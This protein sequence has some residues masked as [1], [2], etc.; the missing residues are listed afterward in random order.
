MV[1]SC[2]KING[3]FLSNQN[4]SF[5]SPTKEWVWF[6]WMIPAGVSFRFEQV[7]SLTRRTTH[8]TF[9]VLS[10]FFL[11][12]FSGRTIG[13]LSLIILL[14]LSFTGSH[15]DLHALIN[16]CILTGILV[17]DVW[18]RFDSHLIKRT[19]VF[20]Y[21]AYSKDISFMSSLYISLIAHTQINIFTRIHTPDVQY[22]KK[23]VA[24][25]TQDIYD[26]ASLLECHFCSSLCIFGG[27]T[28]WLL[29]VFFSLFHCTTIWVFSRLFIL[30]LQVSS[31]V[32]S[33]LQWK[34]V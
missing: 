4:H 19:V 28:V 27:C 23:P 17:I 3:F 11:L 14:C 24:V 6:D 1:W 10:S 21:S 34:K 13:T 26:H 7:V 33:E 18:N 25:H 22:P 15:P 5:S 2:L 8:P 9:E 16:S 30:W 20:S 29:N 32:Q 31:V 12:L